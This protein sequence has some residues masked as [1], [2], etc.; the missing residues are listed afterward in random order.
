MFQGCYSGLATVWSR[1]PF[2]T[3][4]ALNMLLKH[5]FLFSFPKKCWAT[6]CYQ[7]RGTVSRDDWDAPFQAAFLAQTSTP[8]VPTLIGT[9]EFHL[10]LSRLFPLKT[11]NMSNFS[12]ICQSSTGTE[13]RLT[14]RQLTGPCFLTIWDICCK[15]K[16]RDSW[17]RGRKDK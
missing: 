10:H 7:L 11:R 16:E 9:Q 2:S 5:N 13:S 15:G 3:W 8:C 1:S 14:L 4:K 17:R 6:Q 12:K